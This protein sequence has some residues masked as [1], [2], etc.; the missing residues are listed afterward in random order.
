MC[1]GD[2]D[3]YERAGYTV[4]LEE[5]NYENDWQAAGDIQDESNGD[6]LPVT[7]SVATDI[8][9]ERQN[10]DLRLLNAVRPLVGN[11]AL[12]MSP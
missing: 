2:T 9:E 6:T 8:N 4:D 5:R 12:G 10:P 3:H 11:R 1:L 7:G